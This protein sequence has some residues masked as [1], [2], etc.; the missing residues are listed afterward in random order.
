MPVI[1]PANPDDI[2]TSPIVKSGHHSFIVSFLVILV[3]E[4]GD[5][6]FLIAAVMAMRNP[7]YLVGHINRLINLIH[8][9]KKT[10]DI[11][12]CHVGIICNDCSVGAD[13]T[14]TAVN[15]VEAIHTDSSRCA[16]SGVWSATA[17]GR[18]GDDGS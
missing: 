1:P 17:E 16:V 10:V 12:C 8:K 4:I 14:S 18:D 6:T 2:G 13:W 3:S 5:K 15:L 11:L 7:R 9:Q